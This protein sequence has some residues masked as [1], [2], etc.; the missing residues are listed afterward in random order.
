M[1]VISQDGI[2]DFPYENAVLYVEYESV[3]VKVGN[4]RCIIGIYSTEEKAIKAMEMLREK[5]ENNEFYHHTAATDTFEGAMRL[6]SN[7]KFKE[8]T[9]EYFQFPQDDEIEV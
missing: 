1:R 6:L 7:E 2:V 9:S 4:E 5:Y 3:I 8:S